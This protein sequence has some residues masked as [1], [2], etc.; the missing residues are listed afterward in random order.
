MVAAAAVTAG[1]KSGCSAWLFPSPCIPACLPACLTA[2]RFG[3]CY[4]TL[5]VCQY[6]TWQ[7]QLPSLSSLQSTMA[8]SGNL[9]QCL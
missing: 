8:V 3:Y 7:P 4:A 9:W 1:G 2:C 6:Q 5:P